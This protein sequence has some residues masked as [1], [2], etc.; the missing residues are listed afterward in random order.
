LLRP[1]GLP[2]TQVRQDSIARSDVG[3]LLRPAF[4]ARRA[5]KPARWTP[6]GG[7]R[8]L[9]ARKPAAEGWRLFRGRPAGLVV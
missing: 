7:E 1:H 6:V 5:S 2:R 8:R 3:I 4:N 9:F